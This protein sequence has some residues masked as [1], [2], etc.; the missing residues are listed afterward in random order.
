MTRLFE[1]TKAYTDVSF[2]P[3][4]QSRAEPDPGANSELVAREYSSYKNY[5]GLH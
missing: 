3:G 1:A 4:I 2:W 5:D